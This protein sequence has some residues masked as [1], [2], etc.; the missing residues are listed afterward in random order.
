MSHFFHL[1]KHF[2]DIYILWQRQAFVLISVLSK[3]KSKKRKK[4]KKLL[5]PLGLEAQIKRGL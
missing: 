2:C 4:K 3:A 1:I 5:G